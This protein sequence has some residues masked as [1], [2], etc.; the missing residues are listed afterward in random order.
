MIPTG[1]DALDKQLGGFHEGLVILCEESGA[2]A[3]EFALTML[4][5]NAGKFDL[6]Y[7]AIAKTAEEV[8]R[9][10]DL[11]FPEMKR[12]VKIKITTL[13]DYYFRDSIVPM[14]WISERGLLSTLRD[15]KNVLSKLAE[16]FDEVNGIIV[17]D[18][19]TD[20]A[21]VAKRLGWDALIDLL[22]GFKAVCIKRKVLLLALLTSKVLERSLEEELFETADG[23]LIFEWLVERDTITRWMYFRKML[24]IMP[25]LE[26]ER[27]AKFSVKIDPA[28][29]FTISRI[30]RVL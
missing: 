23:V 3:K 4:L 10:I 5:K 14:K 17:L 25:K 30:M 29:G 19:V 22:K 2:G 18:S 6:N 12:E 1:I 7:L 9:E 26:K 13:A 28:Q 8:Q 21:R 16:I 20:L 15:E 27:I 24:G 11:S